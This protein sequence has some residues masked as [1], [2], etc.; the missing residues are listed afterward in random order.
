MRVSTS[1]IFDSGFKGISRN[2]YDLFKLQNQLSTG[3]KVLTPED[4]P[5]ASA[6]AL[7]LTQSKEVSA[8]FLRNQ[9]DAKGKLGVVEGSLEALGN[10]LQNVRERIVQAGNTTLGN[11]DRSY[12]AQELEARFSELMGI[13][14]AQDGTGNY[15]FSGYQGAVT[16]FAM[17]ATGAQYFGD[18]GQRLLQVDASRQLPTNV[19]GSELFEK[20]RN[21]NGA[22]ATATGGNGT[23]INQGSG[24]IDQGSITNQSSWNAAVNAGYGQLEIRFS[25][26]GGVTQYEIFDGGGTSLSGAPVNFVDGQSI[27][28]AKTTAPAQDFGASVVITGQPA[29]GDTFTIS[30]SANQSIFATLRSTIDMLKTGVGS[31]AGGNSSTEFVNALAGN[32]KNIDQSLENVSR[33]RSTVGSGLKEID[34]LANAGEDKQL[35]Y[36][37]S[38]S[39]L[40]DL[41]YAKAI[42]EMSKKQLQ[43][44]AAQLSFKQTSQ[45]SLFNIL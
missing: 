22:F 14:N 41:D 24:V 11:A 42:T 7:V 36:D 25:V 40:Q 9:E 10:L 45:L 1:Q 17:T 23:G 43:L 2:Q 26:A 12:I 37:S 18:D 30:P 8:Q 15:L 27:P 35:Q 20:I 33:V 31:V 13:A 4:D 29:N 6:Q 19:S 21:G 3:R 16:P 34:A 44:E 32:L 39:A 28:L 5:I 38:L